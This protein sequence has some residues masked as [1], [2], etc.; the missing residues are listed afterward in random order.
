MTQLN[1]IPTAIL[2]ALAFAGFCN[3]QEDPTPTEKLSKENTSIK[4]VMKAAHKKPNEL[5]KSVA[6]GKA[7]KPEIERLL[8][9]YKIM[10]QHTPP[11]GDAD[12]WKKKTKLLVEATESVIAGKPD[13]TKLLAKASNCK[14]CHSA[15]K[16]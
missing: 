2:M 3:G 14:S 10:S 15:H 4:D 11:K 5:L 9:L 12:G 13:A 1:R 16:K 6:L 8:K 7:K